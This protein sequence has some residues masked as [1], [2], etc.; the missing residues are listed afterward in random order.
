MPDR[1]RTRRITI[2]TV[3]NLAGVSI[4][5][6]SR[7]INR[8]PHVSETLRRKVEAAIE[9]AQYRPDR[10]ARSLAAS[11]H[12][13]ITLLKRDTESGGST[14]YML[15][16]QNALGR[17]C[18]RL[19]Y[20]LEIEHLSLDNGAADMQRQVAAVLPQLRTDG[21]VLVPPLADDVAILDLIEAAELPYVRISPMLERDRSPAAVIDDWAAAATVATHLMDL[22]HCSFGLVSGPQVHRTAAARAQGFVET[23]HARMPGAP[24]LTEAGDFSFVGGIEAGRR[25]FASNSRPTAIFATNDDSALGVMHAARECGLSIPEDV[26]ICGFDDSPICV[27]VWPFLTTIRQPLEAMAETAVQ[28]LLKPDANSRKQIVTLPFSLIERGSVAPVR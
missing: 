8:E 1:D 27:R 7:V 6:V 17:A 23:V 11:R 16:L 10:A 26:S 15:K 24:I 3:A 22:G 25:L 5:S 2:E 20:H 12:F 18:E 19:T 4:K 9:Q 28:L 14:Y 21:I 13:R